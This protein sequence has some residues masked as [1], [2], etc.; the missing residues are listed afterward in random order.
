MALYI[1][2]TVDYFLMR[3][4]TSK[5]CVFASSTCSTYR[6]HDARGEHIEGLRMA[7]YIANTSFERECAVWQ[8]DGR[9]PPTNTLRLIT[10]K[11]LQSSCRGCGYTILINYLLVNTTVER[12]DKLYFII[13]ARSTRHALRIAYLIGTA[14]HEKY[15]KRPYR[16]YIDSNLLLMD[17]ILCVNSAT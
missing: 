16:A 17:V 6:Q 5:L 10:D 11:Y 7:N 4:R 13:P 12:Y 3:N 1:F 8:R 14:R 15:S 2:L 9:I